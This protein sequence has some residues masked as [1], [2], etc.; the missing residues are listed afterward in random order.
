MK[1]DDSAKLTHM[2]H[3]AGWAAK[4]SPSD[5]EQV[6]LHIPQSNH[7]SLLVGMEN[8][9][10]A[11]VYKLTDETAIVKSLDFFPPI[12][13]DPYYFGSIAVTNALS[14]I[15]SMG[16]T[17]LVGLNIACFPKTMS[18]D[19][20]G[21]ILFGGYEKA[22]EAG[23]VIA[24]GHTIDDPEPKYG[25]EVTGIIK[26]GD[27][28]TNSNAK[29]G[30]LLVLTKPL[31]T[32][33]VT[34]AMKNEKL[35]SDSSIV[36]KAIDVMNTLNRDA[37]FVMKST[38]VNSATDITG[39]GLLG[40]LYNMLKA[41]S[42]S[43]NLIYNNIPLI[44]GALGLVKENTPGGTLSNKQSIE[45]HV[46]FLDSIHG[47]ERVLLYD[48]QTSGGLLISVASDR[49]DYLVTE[50]QKNNIDAKVIGEVIDNNSESSKI[51]VS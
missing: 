20:I 24:G 25:L 47:D 37:S 23:V 12:V 31:G 14:D 42:K 36:L 33:I 41:S 9:D 30:D 6:L 40:H 10:D 26:P 19:I 38:G 17:P 4:F 46:V 49:S 28:I 21:K 29:S 15:Y 51:I 43:A 2:S 13:D 7:S 39:F 45:E 35:N 3:C 5:L 16:A 50:M 34:T 11:A 1:Y 27:E 32:G 22:K 8:N 18:K 48:A 44:E